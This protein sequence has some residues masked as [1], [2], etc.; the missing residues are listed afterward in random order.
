VVIRTEA[1]ELGSIKR[2]MIPLIFFV[3]VYVVVSNRT[4]RIR[5][6]FIYCCVF[7]ETYSP[8]P[9]HLYRSLFLFASSFIRCPFYSV[10]SWDICVFADVS[11]SILLW[12][13]QYDMF[14]SPSRGEK[15]ARR[16]AIF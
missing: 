6:A 10:K 15:L 12:A 7:S 9:I 8:H 5:I 16:S 13:S 2:Y 14:P 11:Q 4:C 3:D 1:T